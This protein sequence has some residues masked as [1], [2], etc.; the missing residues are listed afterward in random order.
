MK[1]E[2][3][4]HDPAGEAEIETTGIENPSLE[5]FDVHRSWFS[6]KSLS[7]S[8]YQYRSIEGYTIPP[9]APLFAM[10]SQ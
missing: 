5:L 10:P 6:G 3:K 7:E 1:A 4:P 2:R 8:A 9:A